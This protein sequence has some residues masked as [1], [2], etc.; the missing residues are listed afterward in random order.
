MGGYTK[1]MKGEEKLYYHK[2]CGHL[3]EWKD[4]HSVQWHHVMSGLLE[5]FHAIQLEEERMLAAEDAAALEQARRR[6]DEKRLQEEE[7]SRL[8]AEKETDA[9]R[10]GEASTRIKKMNLVGGFG[11]KFKAFK[12]SLNC[13]KN[14]EAAVLEI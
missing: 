9:K 4:A 8:E 5:H 11:R 14:T 13:R 12:A 3:K 1:E 6:E 7:A 2:W 10:H